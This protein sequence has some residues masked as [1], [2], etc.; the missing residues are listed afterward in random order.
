[1][2]ADGRVMG[3]YVHGLFAD[4]QQRS[5]WLERLNAAP[6]KLSYETEVDETLDAL[7]EHIERHVDCD[8]LFGMAQKPIIVPKCWPR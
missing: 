3:C 6:S 4:D 7:A 8:A 5:N 2:S 1:M